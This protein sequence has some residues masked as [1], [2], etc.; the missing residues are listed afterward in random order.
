MILLTVP[1]SNLKL[2]RH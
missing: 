1:G 2:W